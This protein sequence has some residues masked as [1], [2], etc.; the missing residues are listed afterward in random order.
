MIVNAGVN[1]SQLP[2]LSDIQPISRI[3]RRQ[4]AVT[5]LLIKGM[6]SMQLPGL[7]DVVCPQLLEAPGA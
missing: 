3:T 5:L 2:I 1:L 6:L 4:I 7:W